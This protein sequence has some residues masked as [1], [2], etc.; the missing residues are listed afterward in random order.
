[1]TQT[2]S[3]SSSSCQFLFARIPVCLTAVHQQ[4]LRWIVEWLH[5]GGN[6]PPSLSQKS[7]RI[8]HIHI[9]SS[10][11]FFF[12]LAWGLI[13]WSF[14]VIS[15]P[16]TL[17]EFPDNCKHANGNQSFW[18]VKLQKTKSEKADKSQLAVAFLISAGLRPRWHISVSIKAFMSQKEHKSSERQIIGVIT[19]RRINEHDDRVLGGS[20]QRIVVAVQIYSPQTVSGCGDVEE[21]TG[22]VSITVYMER[23]SMQQDW[24]VILTM[25]N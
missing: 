14:L 4:Y 15:L 16:K 21:E 8:I 20:K 5:T 7:L 3:P 25:S 19:H 2:C 1:M 24:Y 13:G 11:S 10:S 17:I 12:F 22:S 6:S 9:M 23:A 18:N